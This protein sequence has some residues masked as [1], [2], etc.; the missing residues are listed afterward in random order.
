[1]SNEPFSVEIDAKLGVVKGVV[2]AF[3]TVATLHEYKS[4]IANGKH[5]LVAAGL[6]P[7]LLIDARHQGVQGQEV[8]QGLRDFA[9]SPEG[10]ATRTAIIVESALYRLQI[11]RIRSNE[12]HRTFE[13]EEEA[14]TWLLRKGP[15][16]TGTGR[17]HANGLG[18]ER[19][20]LHLAAGR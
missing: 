10:R 3:W 15:D 14:L 8:V 12:E 16:R 4:A 13:N 5:R 19:R 9:A 2:R 20:S 1:M 11:A 7:R 17:D 6:E 18:L